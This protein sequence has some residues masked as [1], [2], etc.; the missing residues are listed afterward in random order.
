MNKDVISGKI[1]EDNI[2]NNIHTIW[3][4]HV[5]LDRDLAELYKVDNG[6][7]KRQVRRNIE[8]FPEDFMF[9]LTKEELNN[10][11]SQIGISN[12]EKMGIR[13]SPFAFTRDGILTQ[14]CQN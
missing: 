11:R 1:T 5:I 4:Y 7:L 12:S 8:R 14:L 10:W 2:K 13:H 9:E 3:G 6:Y